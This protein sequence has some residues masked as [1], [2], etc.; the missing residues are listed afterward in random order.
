MLSAAKMHI[1]PWSFIMDVS[2]F[3]ASDMGLGYGSGGYGRVWGEE[4][5]WDGM[6]CATEAAYEA[7]TGNIKRK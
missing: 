3:L 1:S 6:G 2:S 5:G 7:A 4:E